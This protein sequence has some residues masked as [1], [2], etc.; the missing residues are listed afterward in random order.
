VTAETNADAQERV[1][2]GS[3]IFGPHAME[4]VMR[5]M[6]LFLFPLLSGCVNSVNGGVHPLRPLEIAMAPYQP[7]VTA[8]L[9]GSLMYEGNCLLFRDEATKA[10]LMPV[11][12]YGSTFNGT[13]LLFHQ[14]G[15]SD[16]RIMVAEEFLMEGQPLQWSTLSGAAYVPFLRQCGMQPFFVSSVRPAN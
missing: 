5:K 8:A 14:P 12:P 13:A 15:K 1:H 3:V 6:I 16:Q 2:S 4:C 9:A 7:T 11:W 10:Y